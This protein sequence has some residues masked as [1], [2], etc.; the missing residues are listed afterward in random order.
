MTRATQLLTRRWGAALFAGSSGAVVSLIQLRHGIIPL[1]DTVTYWSGAESIASGHG[2]HTSLAPS[3]SNFDAVDFARRLGSIPFVDFPIGYP[4]L[5]GCVGAIIGTRSA[6][7]VLGVVACALTA[8]AIVL[9]CP[10]NGRFAIA[11]TTVFAGVVTAVPAMR[12]VTQG[13]L[14]EPLFIAAVM[15]LVV[16][17]GAH[18]DGG[19]WTPVVV[20]AVACSLLRFLGAPL[21]LLAGWEHL[22]RHGSRWRASVWTGAMMAPAAAN[23]A[24]AASVG[25][26]HNAR[27][28][29]VQRADL[30]VFVRSIGG[31]FDGRQGD[32]RRTYFTF[33]GPSW[34]SWPI[35]ATWG[36]VV[37]VAVIGLVTKRTRLPATCE[38][39]LAAAGVLTVGLAA[40]ILGFDA[41]VI[42][43]NR[44]MLPAGILTLTALIWFVADRASDSSVS[45]PELHV[46]SPWRVLAV[47]GLA[48]WTITAVRPWL[49]T[50]RFSDVTRPLAM[51]SLVRELNAALVISNDA[52]GLHWD[53]GVPAAYAPMPVKA[54]TGERVE[55]A[56]IYRLLPCPLAR[57]HG[58]IV[59]SNEST[60]STV[61]RPVLDQ[62]VAEGKL[63]SFTKDG[64]TAYVPTDDACRDSTGS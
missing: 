13:A 55:D 48:V 63:T 33:D 21:A 39:A 64:S 40:G 53:T 47:L 36:I 46:R 42:A 14:S 56:E 31:W 1:L 44:L 60:F 59:I 38:L 22:R 54:L 52:D 34:W 16:S 43:D 29:G 17:L 32:I 20:A 51:S 18:R 26:G 8:A 15:I 37:V 3:F 6:M 11:L 50:E 41:L 9:G 57:A 61:N 25:G 30:D 49:I 12:L 7:L 28:R 10:R 23:I 35:V 45:E 24:W 4:V 5:A 27:W 19:R 62:L 58:V 2:L